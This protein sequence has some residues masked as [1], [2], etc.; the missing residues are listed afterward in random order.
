M[1]D[2]KGVGACVSALCVSLVVL[3]AVFLLLTLYLKG[4]GHTNPAEAVK[5]DVPAAPVEA[6]E[7]QSLAWVL[8]GCKAEGDEPACI[9][10]GYYD[11][12]AGSLSAVVIPPA[13]VVTQAG[14]TDTFT[15]HYDYEGVRGVVHAAA[16]L[17]DTDILRYFRVTSQDVSELTDLLGGVS[18]T[19][20]GDV[21]A[22]GQRFLAGDQLLDGRRLSAFLFDTSRLGVPDTV[23]QADLTGRLF[24]SGMSAELSP[25]MGKLTGLL[26]GECETN[27]SQ[28]DFV[29]REEAF[30]GLLDTAS[31]QTK[32]IPLEGSYNL[33]FSIFTPE[34]ASLD[35][36]QALFPHSIA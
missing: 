16:A 10:A 12:V 5:N 8:L 32:V 27:L 18:Y 19:L 28:Y 14:R 36:A 2:G 33:D 11:A 13:A 22:D 24:F 1:R 29:R 35:A 6:V 20:D 26:L 21:T 4:F 7:E 31:L 30:R 15:G 9:L 3:G 17:L 23:L 25:R 34:T